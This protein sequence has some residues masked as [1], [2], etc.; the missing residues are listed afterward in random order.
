MIS[1]IKR[2]LVPTDFSI[3][4]I[5]A[6]K[7]AAKL[8]NKFGAKITLLNVIDPPFNFPT[9]IEGV[10]EFLTENSEL[11]LAKGIDVI[12]KDYPGS[13]IQINS[14]IRLGKPV[15]QILETISELKIDLVV[16]GSSTDAPARKV[17][18]G[19]VSTDILLRSPK[20]VLAVPENA[21]EKDINLDNLLFTTNYRPN[22]LDNLTHLSNFAR[23]FDS[24]II[25]LHI[26]KINDLKSEIKF[27]GLEQLVKEKKI[28]DKIRFDYVINDEIFEGISTYIESNPNSIIV[29]NRYKK[30]I[31]GLLLDKNY[32]KKL[33]IYSKVPLLVLIGDK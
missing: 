12:K 22:D 26:A 21:D 11:H 13:N 1:K 15:S 33:S 17:I 20:P 2:I 5:K 19:S 24:T 14:Q 29:M 31:V 32:T 27:R 16:M 25:V 6:L 23:H 4:S 18:F 28:Y 9:N 30:S 7:V 8:A 3:T 10:I